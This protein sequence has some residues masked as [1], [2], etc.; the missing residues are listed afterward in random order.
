[1]WVWPRDTWRERSGR[2]DSAEVEPHRDRRTFTPTAGVV[3]PG[4]VRQG[5]VSQ[6]VAL[7]C[8]PKTR[9]AALSRDGAPT[10]TM[11]LEQV[12]DGGRICSL[13]GIRLLTL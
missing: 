5:H 6:A 12:S 2:I 13:P 10:Q 3:K 1:M 4:V 11:N 8:R 9:G 7:S